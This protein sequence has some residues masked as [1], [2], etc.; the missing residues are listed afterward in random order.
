MPVFK[1]NPRGYPH[2][3]Q[4]EHIDAADI[5]AAA[6]YSPNYLSR[7]FRKSV[8]TGIH[9]YLVFIRLQCAALELMATDDSITEIAFRCGFSDSNYFKDAF[10]K[11]YGV[12]PRAYRKRK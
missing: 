9:E 6:G 1:Q 7:K 4:A 5:A 12:T 2:D 11:K 10:K 8:G 3:G